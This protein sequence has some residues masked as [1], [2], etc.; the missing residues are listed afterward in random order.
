MPREHPLYYVWA[1][2]KARCK[3]SNRPDY[4]WYGA[5][6]ITYC[7]RWESFDAWLEDVPS[8][9]EGT[10]FDRIDTDKGYEPGNVKWATPKEQANNRRTNVFYEIE[11]VSKT[12]ATWAEHYGLDSTGYK[13]AHERIK[14]GWDPQLALETPPRKGNYV[15]L[16]GRTL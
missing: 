3:D 16:G 5:R 13:R 8:R 2:M 6:G 14:R 15:R 9:P 12:L 7:E 10:T 11:G 4:I 1:N